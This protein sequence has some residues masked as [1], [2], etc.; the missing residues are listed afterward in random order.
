MVGTIEA[1]PRPPAEKP[2][3]VAR[4]GIEVPR[5]QRELPSEVKNPNP[6]VEDESESTRTVR[7]DGDS[8]DGPA[9]AQGQGGSGSQASDTLGTGSDR[10]NR[11]GI[12]LAEVHRR[13]KNRLVDPGFLSRD[14]TTLLVVDVEK[15]GRVR[16][17]A[18]KTSSGDPSLDR[19]AITAVELGQP[20]PP[21]DEDQQILVPVQF[22]AN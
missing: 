22:H 15:S 6:R 12:Y 21:W 9:S 17:I 14:H 1:L 19:R 16:K 10:S 5:V 18:V 4:E 3:P 2:V 13:I 11:M 20:F 8:T 7:S